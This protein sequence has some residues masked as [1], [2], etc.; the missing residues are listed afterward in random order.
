MSKCS[1]PVY[2]ISLHSKV[3]Y[4]FNK[5]FSNV[6]LIEAV[7][8]RNMNPVHMYNNNY[9][10]LSAYN[11]LEK[12]RKWH[13]ELPGGGAVGLYQSYKKV[14]ELLTYRNEKMFMICEEDCVLKNPQLLIDHCEELKTLDF[15]AAIFGHYMHQNKE[16]KK[17]SM[18]FSTFK[19]I[20]F[21]THC[22]IWSLKGIKK[23]CEYFKQP[24]DMQIDSIFSELNNL[25][26]L[27]LLVHSKNGC[28][29][30]QYEHKSTL[31]ND[32]MCMVCDLSP[33][34]I[35]PKNEI[36]NYEK[37]IAIFIMLLILL[38][39]ILNLTIKKIS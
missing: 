16:T 17:V 13:H 31:E 29:A 2:I 22:M 12:G 1:I 28:D 34:F 11:S 30:T 4:D 6:H 7:N 20:F 38:V 37:Y 5:H 39:S 8:L 9:I 32:K 35:N 19:G 26:H 25:K 33:T 15:D 21:R 23:I 24:Q 36:H 3:N 14:C 18:N 10:T 27:K